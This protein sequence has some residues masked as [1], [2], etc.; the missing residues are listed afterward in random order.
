MTYN[1]FGVKVDQT[2]VIKY[3]SVIEELKLYLK[4]RSK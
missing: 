3:S 4:N 1:C 2:T